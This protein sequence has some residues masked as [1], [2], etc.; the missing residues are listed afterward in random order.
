[1]SEWL[2]SDSDLPQPHTSSKLLEGQVASP[3]GLSMM[4]PCWEYY[5]PQEVLDT[6][7][8]A[9]HNVHRVGDR[10]KR[11]SR[12]WCVLSKPCCAAGSLTIQET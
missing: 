6:A 4:L 1:M 10:H 7:E 8:K 3:H 12:L 5:N 11:G 2:E 9:I